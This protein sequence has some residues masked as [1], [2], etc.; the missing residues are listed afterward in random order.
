MDLLLT[1]YDLDIT[2]GDL[3]WVTGNEATAQDVTMS[4]RTWLAE[5]VYDRSAGVPYRQV[6]FQRGITSEAVQFIIE[7]QILAVPNISAVLELSSELDSATREYS[8]TGKALAEDE[9]IDFAT[10]KIA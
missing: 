5:S 4:L 2:N 8:C 9:E 1:D 7:Q 6:I 3:S 10:G